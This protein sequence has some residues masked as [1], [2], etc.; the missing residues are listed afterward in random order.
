M[1]E[2]VFQ[3]QDHCVQGELEY[4]RFLRAL[5]S[6]F[7][8]S[9]EALSLIENHESN[10]NI[11]DILATWTESV[12]GRLNKADEQ[13]RHE[14][15]DL[16]PPEFLVPFFKG[17]E[18]VT[19]FCSTGKYDDLKLGKEAFIVSLKRLDYIR[20]QF[21]DND[22]GNAIE[23]T[24]SPSGPSSPGARSGDSGDRTE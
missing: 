14:M 15:G 18:H 8:S 11:R 13:I 1:T 5:R 6:Y 22:E 21:D 4:R 3:L 2:D 19:R 17:H 24:P 10:T 23:P 9:G 20:A 16:W 7:D 12:Q